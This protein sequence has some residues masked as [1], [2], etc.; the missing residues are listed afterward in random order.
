MRKPK[1]FQ[2]IREQILKWGYDG[3]VISTRITTE[4]NDKGIYVWLSLEGSSLRLAPL[5]LNIDWEL[6]TVKVIQTEHGSGSK[7]I[8]VDMF[9]ISERH[10][11]TPREFAM[12]VQMQLGGCVIKTVDGHK[13]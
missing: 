1:N 13:K 6:E 7:G 11:R 2:K 3:K 8:V 4:E 10:C 12:Y 9:T 5:Y